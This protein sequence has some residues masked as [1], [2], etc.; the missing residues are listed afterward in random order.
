MN[1]RSFIETLDNLY[2]NKDM[3]QAEVHMASSLEWATKNK[4]R[5]LMITVLNEQVCYYKLTC[6]RDRAI[7]ACNRITKLTE[8]AGITDL[9]S[10]AAILVNVASAYCTLGNPAESLEVFRRVESIYLLH[11]EPTDY[12]IAAL[13]NNMSMAFDLMGDAESALACMDTALS[14]LTDIP[15]KNTEMATTHGNMGQLYLKCGQLDV[16]EWHLKAAMDIFGELEDIDPNFASVLNG[17][18][19]MNYLRGNYDNAIGYYHVAMTTIER[20]YGF[21]RSYETTCRNCALAYSKAGDIEM[22]TQM[23]YLADAAAGAIQ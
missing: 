6:N 21:C 19:Q 18:G 23:N 20:C 7:G 1:G 9:V 11:I 3:D 2:K 14:I 4:N 22:A 10:L 16:A 17:M 5:E 8:E 12:R 13:Y 15:E